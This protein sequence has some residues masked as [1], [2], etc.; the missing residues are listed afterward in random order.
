LIRAPSMG[1]Q[2]RPVRPARDAKNLVD[3]HRALD[4]GVDLVFDGVAF[5]DIKRLIDSRALLLPRDAWTGSSFAFFLRL[6]PCLCLHFF[7]AAARW[8]VGV[9]VPDVPAPVAGGDTKT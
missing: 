6:R 4:P 5:D 9:V 1:R 7:S 2:D 3:A 8:P